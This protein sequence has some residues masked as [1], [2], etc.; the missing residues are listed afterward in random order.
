MNWRFQKTKRPDTAE[1]LFEPPEWRWTQSGDVGWWVRADWQHALLGPKGLRLEEWQRR[2]QLT[3]VKK[4]NQRIV[5]RAEPGKG[6][7]VYVKHFLVPGFREKNR[8]WVRRGK[9]RNEGQRTRYLNALGVPT[10]T[11]V[12]LGEQRRRH[13]L[14]ENYLITHAIP[15]AISLK[16]SSS[17]APQWAPGR[18]SRLR[19]NLAL[20]WPR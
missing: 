11:P 19:R 3:V 2:G 16:S 5:Y 8:Q 20:S 15:D 13:L 10:I 17:A 18:Q 9:G 6:E 4:H 1:S 14:L 7:A 12:A